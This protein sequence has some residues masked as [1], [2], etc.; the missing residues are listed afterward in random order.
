MFSLSLCRLLQNWPIILYHLYVLYN[1]IV[2]RKYDK[3]SN[4]I[5]MFLLACGEEDLCDNGQGKCRLSCLSMEGE[6]GGCQ[7]R[8]CK[9]CTV[10]LAN[11][12]ANLDFPDICI[13]SRVCSAS[14]NNNLSCGADNRCTSCDGKWKSNKLGR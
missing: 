11:C 1:H 9:C 4:T 7:N 13:D 12:S 2:T 6:V 14:A 5:N 10:R 8:G 3:I